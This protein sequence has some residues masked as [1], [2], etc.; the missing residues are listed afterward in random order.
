MSANDRSFRTRSATAFLFLANTKIRKGIA[1]TSTLLL[2]IAS[3]GQETSPP[4]QPDSKTTSQEALSYAKG[5]PEA[6]TITV[7]AGTRIALVLTH[8][9]QSRVYPPRR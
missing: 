9:I 1:L 5:A 8:P 4:Q 7:P 6:T 2:A 3:L